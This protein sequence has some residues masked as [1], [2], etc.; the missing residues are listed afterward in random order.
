MS[1]SE[2]DWSKQTPTSE[3]ALDELFASSGEIGA[4]WRAH[5]IPTEE[6]WQRGLAAPHYEREIR[7]LNDHYEVTLRFQ[8]APDQ[9]LES[10][11]MGWSLEVATLR[12]YI[13]VMTRPLD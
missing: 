6:A 5:G 3:Q 2:V 12:A 9:V 13:D 8:V 4:F 1:L 11:M 10:T 7:R